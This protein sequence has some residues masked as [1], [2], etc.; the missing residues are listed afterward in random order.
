MKIQHS[1]SLSTVV[2][3]GVLGVLPACT[4]N[5]TVS[6][7]SQPPDA[8]VD[9][10]LAP[11]PDAPTWTPPEVGGVVDASVDTTPCQ[12]VQCVQPGGTYCGD[13]PDGCG[14][15]LACGNDCPANQTCGGSGTP[16][17]C[18]DPNCKPV[19]CMGPNYKYCGTIGDGCG[20]GL[21]CGG[22]PSPQS[23]TSNV[24]G[25]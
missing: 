8:A 13:I 5:P 9:E 20:H 21:D 14:K 25:P 6:A 18:G 23:C 2:A 22:C 16:H 15:I 19:A 17:L 12:P 1:V 4:F 10:Q 11:Q 24:C 7:L 3:V